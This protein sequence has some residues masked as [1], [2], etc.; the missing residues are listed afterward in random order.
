MRFLRI[1]PAVVFTFLA[2]P[3][4]AQDPPKRDV[5]ALA[6]LQASLQ[7]MGGR[8]PD[9]S[10]AE[11]TV[12]LVEGSKT[13]SGTIRILTRG[14]DQTFEEIQTADEHRTVT[15]SRGQAK[16]SD[17]ESVEPSSVE[18][19]ASSQALDFLLPFLFG[20]LENT[21]F[22][23]EYVGLEKVEG[24]EVHHIRLQNTFLSQRR[25]KDIAP[26][27]EKHVWISATSN[28][29]VKV[30]YER[31]AARG[32]HPSIPLTI[33]FSDYRNIAGI[34]YPFRIEKTFNGSP[35]AAIV[36]DQVR[37]NSNLSDSQFKVE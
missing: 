29:P 16:H 32:A 23:F 4:A 36:I 35:W 27:T 24:Q 18:L 13:Q 30:A 10:T 8:L 31:R 9:D 26:L 34:L 2:V 20:A 21:D 3:V 28:L 33:N 14:K 19:A 25:L 1:V 15:F 12:N 5:Q 11:G 37:F 22:S 6:V 17:A 7:A